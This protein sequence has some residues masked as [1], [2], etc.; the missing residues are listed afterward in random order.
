MASTPNL[1]PLKF[2]VCESEAA[3]CGDLFPGRPLLRQRVFFK[4][5][6]KEGWR[7]ECAKDY[8]SS[9]FHSP[10]LLSA[11]CA[12]EHPKLLGV[13]VMDESESISTAINS[14]AA[15]FSP[16]P[17]IVYYD[18]ACNLT[19]SVALRFRWMFSETTF[20]CDRFH[21]AGHKCPGLF[22]PDTHNRCD[23]IPKSG[24]ERHASTYDSLKRTISFRF[25]MNA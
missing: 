21:Y 24:A 20:V 25:F 5:S 10:G 14:I 12:C 3:E 15:R 2:T 7:E 16:L 18:N 9:P 22:D 19:K 17:R 23:K 11:Q 8:R 4:N 1:I 6:K 13:S